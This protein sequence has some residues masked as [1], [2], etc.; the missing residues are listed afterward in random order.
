MKIKTIFLL[1]IVTLFSCNTQK[2]IKT[3][4]ELNK[5]EIFEISLKTNPTTGYLWKWK[6]DNSFKIV[7]SLST[8]YVQD[9]TDAQMTGVGGNIVWK[10]KAKQTGID[11]LTFEYCRSWEENS[12][13]ETKK[14]IVKIY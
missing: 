9:K 12:T 13:V 5:N 8:N 14:F 6:K 3:D 1:L 10:F 11:T 7:D 2:N 4:F